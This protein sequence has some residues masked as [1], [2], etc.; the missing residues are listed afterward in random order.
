MKHFPRILARRPRPASLFAAGLAVALLGTL[1]ALTASDA[2][3]DDFR[4]DRQATVTSGQA[5][6]LGD[7]NRD[8]RI[9]EDESGWDCR[10]MGNRQCGTASL[11]RGEVEF[12]DVCATVA[13][14]PAYAWTDDNGTPHSVPSGRELL[15]QVDAEPGTEEFAA[16]LFA[17]D[18]QWVQHNEN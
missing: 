1:G 18:T 12:A 4:A 14:R 5:D 8:G 10:T 11:C 2:T 17:L 15:A 16:A 13:A 3:M 9:D 7:D 6:A